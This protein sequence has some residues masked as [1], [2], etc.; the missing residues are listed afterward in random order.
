M[1][2][3]RS[4]HRPFVT[5]LAASFALAVLLP[6]ASRAA[7]A[8]KTQAEYEQVVQKAVEYL[9]TKGQT[10]DGSF[11]QAGPAV[12]AIIVTGLI[13]NGRGVDDPMVAKGLKYL[14]GFVRDDGGIYAPGSRIKNYDTCVNLLAFKAANRNRTTPK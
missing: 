7:D 5:A 12:T 13:E 11:A 10:A 9:R 3:R 4:P 6:G 8:A 14:E 1:L 2:S